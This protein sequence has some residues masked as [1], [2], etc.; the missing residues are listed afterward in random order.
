MLLNGRTHKTWAFIYGR[1]DRNK[2]R[3][4]VRHQEK[5]QFRREA[6]EV[7]RDRQNGS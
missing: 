2:N 4:S 5:N 7:M 1:K 3:R 6:D